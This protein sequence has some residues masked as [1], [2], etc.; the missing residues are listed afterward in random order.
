MQGVDRTVKYSVYLCSRLVCT[1]IGLCRGTYAR[2][3]SDKEPLTKG[4]IGYGCVHVIGT[5][6]EKAQVSLGSGD[7]MSV[8]GDN[9]ASKGAEGRS[10]GIDAF[11]GVTFRRIAAW[12]QGCDFI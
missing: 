8:P 4:H 12:R 11:S 7:V 9:N 10:G 3:C 6:P 1:P 5:A 2:P